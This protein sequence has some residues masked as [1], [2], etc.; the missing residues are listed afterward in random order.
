[1]NTVGNKEKNMTILNITNAENNADVLSALSGDEPVNVRTAMQIPM[2]SRCVNMI[3]G[4]VAML[5]IKLYRRTGD[6]VEEIKEDRRLDILNRDTGDTICADYMRYAW[7]RDLLLTGAAYAYIERRGTDFLP[8]RLY[9]VASEEISRDVN[10]TDPIKKIYRYNIGG[11]TAE[12]WE[13]LKIL[14][15]TDGYGGGKGILEENPEMI[16]TAYGLIK[17]QKKQVSSGGAKRGILRTNGLK[18]DVVEEIKEK[19]AALWGAKNDR[20]TMFILNS[21]DSDFKE[22]SSTSVDMQLNQTQETIDKELMK[23]FGT[24]DGMLTEETVKNAVLPVIDIIEAALDT[25]LLYEREKRD[26]YFAFDTR[27]L[28]RG[29][30][31][32]RYNAYATALSQ[33]FMQL[34]EVRELEDL[35]PL[36]INFVKLGLNDV[37]LDPK[38]GQI[39]TPNTNAYAQMGKNVQVPLTDEVESGT[40]ES[41]SNPNHVPAGSKK[42]GQFA[43]KVSATGANEFEVKDFRNKQKRK[44]HFKDHKAEFAEDGITTEEQYVA[45]ALSLAES[46]VDGS[47]VGH[48][49]GHGNVIRY[50][51]EK[52]RF[53]KGDPS[54]G[55]TTFF[56]PETGSAYYNNQLKED[57]KHG[58]STE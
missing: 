40:I 24:N 25:D 42:G 8:Y 48:K 2:V 30:I 53:V 29:D 56:M 55:L 51:K 39:Y 41:R 6:G 10:R 1:M 58:G 44:N 50:D 22:L 4:A 12:P 38:T 15:N 34:D 14:R 20:D 18:K 26:C 17:Y 9:Y 5:P 27:E 47:V 33:N 43:S 21:K 19:W 7:V 23:L 49:D 31:N 36:G 54:K 35:P 32:Q 13:M 45:E 52:N 57:M 28:T 46:P 11:R 37:L 16:A 3:A